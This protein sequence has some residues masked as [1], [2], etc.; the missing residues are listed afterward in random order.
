MNQPIKFN[1]HFKNK[2]KAKIKQSPHFQI[3]HKRNRSFVIGKKLFKQIE[4]DN[5][6]NQM[7][8]MHSR[9]HRLLENYTS[10]GLKE[11]D[12]WGTLTKEKLTKL[13][14]FGRNKKNKNLETVTYNTETLTRLV[15]NDV[16]LYI[17]SKR[18]FLNDYCKNV[19]KHLL[20]ISDTGV[21]YMIRGLA[22]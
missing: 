7:I 22:N 21:K 6:E 15:S 1:T 17:P 2:V 12:K 18:I 5:N 9:K 8:S 4:K 16:K 20:M 3:K 11:P 13:N 19:K 14:V 10:E